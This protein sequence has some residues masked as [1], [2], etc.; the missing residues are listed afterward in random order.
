MNGIKIRMKLKLYIFFLLNAMLLSCIQMNNKAEEKNHEH[1]RLITKTEV[2]WNR[3]VSFDGDANLSD[4]P[5]FYYANEFRKLTIY[6]IQKIEI[7]PYDEEIINKIELLKLM[8]NSTQ[9]DSTINEEI[10]ALLT[11]DY[12]VKVKSK[13]IKSLLLRANYLFILQMTTAIERI[14][15]QLDTIPYMI[16]DSEIISKNWEMSAVLVIPNG[17]LIEFINFINDHDSIKVSADNRHFI[18]VLAQPRGEIDSISAEIKLQ[19]FEE[20][21]FLTKYY[22]VIE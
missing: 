2:V 8:A 20:V 22:Q 19:G 1:E 6:I 9:I 7:A 4:S 17:E 15:Q 13:E 10:Q 11:F 18:R 5:M 3:L 16:S 21:I 14:K 12:N